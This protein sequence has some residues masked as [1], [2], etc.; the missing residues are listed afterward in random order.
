MLK[1]YM[2]ALSSGGL[3]SEVTSVRS[4]DV[5]PLPGEL[6]LF[7]FLSDLTVPRGC[8]GTGTVVVLVPTNLVAVDLE[9]ASPVTPSNT[10]KSKGI[11]YISQNS[12]EHT[13]FETNNFSTPRSNLFFVIIK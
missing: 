2:R 3:V 8:C 7:N 9:T 4:G 10:N 6:T 1:G 12:T 5:V 11:G 13:C